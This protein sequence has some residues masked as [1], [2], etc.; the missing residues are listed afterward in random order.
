MKRQHGGS[1][2]RVSEYRIPQNLDLRNAEKRG[3]VL[4][5]SDIGKRSGQKIFLIPLI[6]RSDE[7]QPRSTSISPVALLWFE[8]WRG[9]CNMVLIL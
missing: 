5:Y 9:E 8:M 1:H 4:H 2:R 3:R 6:L 7:V